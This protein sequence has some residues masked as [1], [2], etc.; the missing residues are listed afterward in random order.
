V[1][2]LRELQPTFVSVTY[3]AVSDIRRR[4]TIRLVSRIKRDLGIEAMAHL[5]CVNSSR[6]DLQE[7]LDE[8][9]SNGIEN[10]MALRGDPPPGEGKFVPQ[11]DGFA[12]S[13]ELV[14]HVTAQGFCAGGG[15]YPQIHPDSRT[16]DED[17]V[18]LAEKVAA[19]AQFLVTQA[20]FDNIH[21]FAFVERARKAGIQVPIVPGIMPATSVR[22]IKRITTL[23]PR[24]TIPEALLAELDRRAEDP[25]AVLELGVAHATL[26]CEELLRCGAPG[27]HF[28]TLNASP[29][30]SA[31]LAALKIKQP[32]IDAREPAPALVSPHP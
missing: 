32:W 30:T 23:D 10:I 12:N 3:D 18:H 17:L 29:A 27:I 1:A 28:Y 21:Y 25:K 15:C 7:K 19:G 26:Q 31:I 20:F 16:M 24:A 9:K 8:L 22:V 4:R 5:T 2:R 11:A 14:A 6:A 13:T